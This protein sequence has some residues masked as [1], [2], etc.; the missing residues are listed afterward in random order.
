LKLHYDER[1]SEFAF[2]CNLRHYN[3]EAVVAVAKQFT[4]MGMTVLATGGTAKVIE[5]G[6]GFRF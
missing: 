4:D 2:K 3:K 6:L 1:P 5:V